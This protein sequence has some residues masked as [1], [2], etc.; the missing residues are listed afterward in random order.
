M[1]LRAASK[2]AGEGVR[3]GVI[4]K[5][6]QQPP[7]IP[8]PRT[9][10]LA[11]SATGADVFAPGEILNDTYEVRGVLG[12]GGTA[13]VFEAHDLLLNRTVAIKAAWPDAPASLLR[14]EAQALAV[15]R[16]PALVT[17]HS[18]GV[19]RHIDYLV[20]ERI[21]GV[22]LAAHLAQKRPTGD[23]FSIAETVDVLIALAEGLAAV[24]RA[25]I[26]HRDVTPANIML[27]P[28]NRV[29]IMDFGLVL[30]EF[31]ASH[32]IAGTPQYMAPEAIANSTA[33]G[34]GFLIDIYA[35]G[36]IAYKM[37]TGEV[38][39]EGA[40]VLDT[41]QQ[42]LLAPIPDVCQVRFD[43]PARL[44]ALVT[45]LLAKEPEDRPQSMDHVLWELRALRS[46]FESRSPE[47]VY[48]VLVVDDDAAIA[49]IV[50]HGVQKAVPGAEVKVVQDAERALETI[51]K[52]P[53]DVILVDLH[54]PRMN[55]IELCMYLRG[56]HFCD[57]STIISVSASASEQDVTLLQQLGISRFI[58]K[59]AGLIDKV[60]QVVREVHRAATKGPGSG[61]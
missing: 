32:S 3:W 40:S 27:A 7:T 28:G 51:R 47:A 29:V 59:G 13:Q 11:K 42:H 34:S 9:A 10:E 53:P 16:H 43:V 24:H 41:W 5:P 60:A 15:V 8:A 14:Q 18:L 50:A 31:S 26:A 30:P 19:H 12:S 46:R 36:I 56:T 2:R 54:M 44:G 22:T 58:P 33:A 4:T 39:F 38:P 6:R 52:R 25:G 20:M 57:R 23:A 17:I 37:L 1:A 49:R 21:Y 48:S 61:A 35:L 55:G 45:A